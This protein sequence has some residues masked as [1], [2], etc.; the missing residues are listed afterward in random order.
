MTPKPSTLLR[1]IPPQ[2]HPNMDAPGQIRSGTRTETFKLLIHIWNPAPANHAR[3]RPRFMWGDRALNRTG[4][5]RVRAG[6]DRSGQPPRH[7]RRRVRPMIKRLV[8]RGH[9]QTGLRE[10]PRHHRSPSVPS[11]PCRFPPGAAT[12]GKSGLSAAFPTKFGTGTRFASA[13]EAGPE[14]SF[15]SAAL[16]PPPLSGRNTMNGNRMEKRLGKSLYCR[17]Y[18]PS[19]PL[20]IPHTSLLP[21]RSKAGASV[22]IFHGNPQSAL[23]LGIFHAI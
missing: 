2:H 3:E 16:Q 1:A 14:A 23:D 18:T 8:R 20:T 6:H 12:A 7:P 17:N 19:E 4:R 11:A 10:C 5:V 21:Y 15:P 13:G 22:E 9:R